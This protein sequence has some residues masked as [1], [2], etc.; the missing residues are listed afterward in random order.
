M[1]SGRNRSLLVHLNSLKFLKEEFDNDPSTHKYKKSFIIILM[2][3]IGMMGKGAL[4][5][6][7]QKP[8]KTSYKKEVIPETRE[9]LSAQSQ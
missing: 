1:T 6:D 9:Q 3:A 2:F 4:Y 7:I 8:T 5:T